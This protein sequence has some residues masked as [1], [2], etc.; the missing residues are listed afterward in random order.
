MYNFKFKFLS[1][2]YAAYQYIKLG[3]VVIK[4]MSK[5]NARREV[6][7]DGQRTMYSN[8]STE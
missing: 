2:T 7:G 3:P 4:K 6:N 1:L 8:R 5:E